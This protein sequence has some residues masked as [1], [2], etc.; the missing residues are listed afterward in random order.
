MQRPKNLDRSAR[1]L[2]EMGTVLIVDISGYTRFVHE[3]D[4]IQGSRVMTR[5]LG[6][7]METNQLGLR[8]SEIEGDAILFYLP[9][10]PPLPSILK[11]QFEAMID[12]F[13]DLTRQ[14][15][16]SVPQASRLSI[17]MV[18]HYGRIIE[19]SLKG[20]R[21]LYGEAVIEAHRL[22]KNNVDS[23]TYIL[24]TEIL[25]SFHPDDACQDQRV[26]HMCETYDFGT[27]CYRYLQYKRPGQSDDQP[28]T[29]K[30]IQHTPIELHLAA[31]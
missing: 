5:L 16:E 20:F 19:F 1:N 24:I 13:W 29:Q 11:Q 3:A 23:N 30:V 26:V 15:S 27:I 8:V 10:R 22:L 9:G 6:V 4:Y 17:K 31:S 28:F 14:M 21:K 7:L 12:G 25:L 2:D 18:A